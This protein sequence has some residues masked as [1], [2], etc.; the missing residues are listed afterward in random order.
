[1]MHSITGAAMLPTRPTTGFRTSPRARGAKECRNREVQFI[2]AT[3][4]GR[5]SMAVLLLANSQEASLVGRHRDWSSAIAWVS[6]AQGQAF[7]AMAGVQRG[8]NAR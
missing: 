4:W 2:H 1:M 3:P 5:S 6:V 8:G 7:R